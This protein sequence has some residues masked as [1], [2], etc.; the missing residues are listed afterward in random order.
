M[1][2]YLLLLVVITFLIS[3]EKEENNN[4]NNNTTTIP[5]TNPPVASFTNSI[6]DYTV[7]FINTSTND[8]TSISW[9]LGDNQTASG[10][11][12]VHTYDTAGTYQIVLTATNNDGSDTANLSITIDHYYNLAEIKTDFGTLTI[13]L[14]DKTPQ[15][16]SNFLMLADSGFYD[17]TTFHRIIPGFVIQGGDPLS[18]DDDPD[19][20]GTGGPGYIIPAEFDTSLTHVYG[21]VASA[22]DDNPDKNSSGSQFYI[23]VGTNGAH[24]LDMNYT[25]FGLVISNMAIADDISDQPVDISDRPTTDIVMDVDVVLYSRDELLS[26]FSFEPGNN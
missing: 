14:Y 7:T 17:S 25:T 2:N 19:N 4:S 16:K 22:R 15:H 10:D 3:C 9:D 24:N 18:K 23:V 21:A 6:D 13:W 12:V 11:T 8:P 20:D 5:T 1:K 26:N